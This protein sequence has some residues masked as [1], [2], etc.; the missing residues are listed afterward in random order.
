MSKHQDHL[1]KSLVSTAKA[2]KL[3]GLSAKELK[4]IA[5]GEGLTTKII[6]KHVKREKQS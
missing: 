6:A 2:M 5:D 3:P 4:D 1:P